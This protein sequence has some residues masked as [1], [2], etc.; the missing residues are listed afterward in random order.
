[1]AEENFTLSTFYSSW[2]EYQ[3]RLK[4]SLAPLTTEQLALRAAPDL[5]SVGE[6]AAHLVGCRAGWFTF[7]L[8]EDVGAEVK[9][10]ATWDE[11]GAPA[12]TGAELV[13]G[14][15][16]TWQMMA[17]CL[18]RWSPDDMRKTFTDDWDGVQVEL[19]RAWIIWHLIEHDLAHGAEVSFTLGMHGLP[20]GFTG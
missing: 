15:D 1:V 2:K 20:A 9:A 13:E 10:I 16:R 5:R 7:V 8:G 3:D 19:S 11:G 4:E 17:D 14:L 12:R 6:N 18:A